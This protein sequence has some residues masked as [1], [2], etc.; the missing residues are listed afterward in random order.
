MALVLVLTHRIQIGVQL[1]IYA[2]NEKDSL[3]SRKQNSVSSKEYKFFK[4]SFKD[5]FAK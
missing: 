4:V 1:L 3:N 2:V 5:E